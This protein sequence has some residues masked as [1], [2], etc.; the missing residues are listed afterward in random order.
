MVDMK[1]LFI[2][3]I[4]SSPG[5][6]MLET[7]LPKLREKYRPH[8]TIVNGENAA[9]GNGIT[10]KIYRQFLNLGIH[11]VTMG[12][13]TWDKKEIFDFIDEAHYLVRPANYPKGTPGRGIVYVN[14][15]GT[16]V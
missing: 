11:V 10:E 14:M 6:S 12:N 15:N 1:I 2:G 16:E 3:D 4:V 9:G 7:Y 13:H 5:R 8:L